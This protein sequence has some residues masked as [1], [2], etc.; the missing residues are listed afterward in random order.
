MTEEEVKLGYYLLVRPLSPLPPPQLTPP[1]PQFLHRPSPNPRL[2]PL[3]APSPHA[4]TFLSTA[5]SEAPPRSVGETPEEGEVRVVEG[6]VVAS[7]NG[8]VL[9][10]MGSDSWV[11]GTEGAVGRVE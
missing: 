1:Y 5:P 10:R 3:L 4:L 2:S 9:S 8:V 11:C 7:E 6:F